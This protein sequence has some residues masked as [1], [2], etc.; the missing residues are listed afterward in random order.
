MFSWTYIPPSWQWLPSVTTGAKSLLTNKAVQTNS[1]MEEASH[2]P[3]TTNAYGHSH[4]LSANPIT[5]IQQDKTTNSKS[6]IITDNSKTP[7]MVTPAINQHSN[8][9]AEL[10]A[11]AHAALFSPAMS[12]LKMALRKGFL[13][14]FPGL[15]KASLT[16]FLPSIEATSM[17][18][19]D[20]QQ[21]H[22]R[23]QTHPARHIP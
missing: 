13:P 11:F 7:A 5:V 18:H 12:T 21:K 1:Q 6:K 4:I 8:T 9:M 2:A 20:A 3:V 23:H 10:V 17:G 19:L 14:L 15:T 16:C 22:L